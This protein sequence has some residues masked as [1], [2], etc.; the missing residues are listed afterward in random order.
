[1]PADAPDPAAL[2]IAAT[3]LVRTY[4]M[5]KQEVRALDGVSIEVRTGEW[6]A[7][8][9]ASGSGKSTL[10]SILGCLDRPT[11]GS[12][13]L[14]GKEVASLGDDEL[15][16]MR[17]E[18]LGFVFQ[19]F[20]LL[21]GKRADQNVALPL[22]YGRP[23]PPDK[24]RLERARAALGRVGLGDRVD[25]KPGELSGGQKQRVAIARALVGEP[26]VLLADEP[27]GNLDSVSTGEILALF[28]ELHESGRTIVMV[29]HSPEVAA[30]AD[31]RI[32]LADGQIERE[33]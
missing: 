28:Q 2:V 27:T 33:S 13:R 19:S 30:L 21:A 26:A 15:A 7:L 29:T 14:D 24:V 6:V 12:Y 16:H 8:V 23:P 3:D 4:A 17:N 10:L 32:H 11:S 22:R 1:M 20:N 25:H 18:R 5:G 31:R 9:G